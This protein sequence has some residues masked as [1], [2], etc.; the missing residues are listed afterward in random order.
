MAAHTKYM[1][2]TL[3][4]DQSLTG[5]QKLNFVFAKRIS[6]STMPISDLVGPSSFESP[7]RMESILWTAQEFFLSHGKCEIAE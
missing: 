7:H 1:A 3:N 6:N 2:I 4:D 5:I